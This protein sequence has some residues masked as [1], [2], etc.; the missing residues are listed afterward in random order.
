MQI[1][2]TGGAGFIGSHL[3]EALLQEGHQVKVMDILLNGNKLPTEV[4]R[5]VTFFKG[6]VRDSEST[7]AFMEGCDVVVHFAAVLGVDVVADN[8]MLTMETEVLGAY[9]IVQ[10][11]RYHKIQKLIY[12]S[13]SGIYDFHIKKG[14]MT[15]DLRVD[16][17][18]SYAAAKRYVERYL[19]SASKQY[20]WDVAALRFFNIYGP[21]QDTRMVVPR[22]FQQALNQEP[23]TV[24]GDGTQ[25]R[26]F[27]F[28]QDAVKATIALMHKHQG[29]GIYNICNEKGYSILELAKTIKSITQ[30][31]SPII[32]VPPPEKRKS[33]ES[34]YRLGSAEKLYRA[35]GFKPQTPLEEGLKQCFNALLKAHS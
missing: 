27:T 30:S 32:H 23:I 6:D 4:Q 10:G 25:V 28:V 18:S 8:P 21:R 13:T 14:A 17:V 1:L 29:F 34:P 33:Y 26:D 20:G 35:I 22:F 16:P 7:L 15:E 31:S 12:A 5:S 11:M 2:V 19:E 9:S 24:Y 3:V